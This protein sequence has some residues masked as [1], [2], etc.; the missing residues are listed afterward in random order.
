[1]LTAATILDTSSRKIEDARLA[2]PVETA[3][4]TTE[5]S[6]DVTPVAVTLTD[7]HVEE[8]QGLSEDFL[9]DSFISDP[10]TTL[11]STDTSTAPASLDTSALST[12]AASL[13]T[14]TSMG[15]PVTSTIFPQSVHAGVQDHT[16]STSS[17]SVRVK[18]I[19]MT[20]WRR[21]VEDFVK[22][23]K[24]ALQQLRDMCKVLG[25]KRGGVARDLVVR[26]TDRMFTRQACIR[27]EL[28]LTRRIDVRKTAGDEKPCA[29]FSLHL[30]HQQILNAGVTGTIPS[31]IPIATA[32]L[33]EM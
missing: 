12:S 2:D 27:G 8:G 3:G 10:S 15:S 16:G 4:S 6:T 29:V 7:Y 18:R 5:D 25:L 20:K 31:S 26:I 1:M 13:V 17:G 28:V 32:L 21:Q 11:A 9:E 22:T 33:E 24:I 23:P 14:S 30:V 19:D